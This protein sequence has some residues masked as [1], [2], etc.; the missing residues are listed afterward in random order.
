LQNSEA[1][2]LFFAKPIQILEV[3]FSPVVAILEVITHYINKVSGENPNR[4]TESELR[5]VIAIGQEEGLLDREATKRLQS[6]LDFERITVKQV[7][8]P[9][10]SV[11]SFDGNLTIEQFL[12]IS[13]DSPYD[14]Y[15]LYE[16]KPENVTGVLDVIDVMRAT[17]EEKFST[18]LKEI[19]RS[20]FYVKQDIRLDEVLTQFR[21]KRSSMGIVVGADGKM[22]GVFTSQDIVEEIV[23]DI[24][25]EEVVK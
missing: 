10:A 24:F 16:G 12:D 11:V 4:L 15:P 13:L 19:M 22:V 7:M 3:I 20:T 2:S 14:H 23:G 21:P 5:S 17:K 1:V 9:K 6:V 8:T 25:E 18:K